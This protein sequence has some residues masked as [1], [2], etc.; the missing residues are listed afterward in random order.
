VQL[1]GEGHLA[2]DRHRIDAAGKVLTLVAVVRNDRSNTRKEYAKNQ[3]LKSEIN[4]SRTHRFGSDTTT[5]NVHPCAPY[6]DPP[7][8]W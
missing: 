1:V 4:A 3:H 2:V 7:I 6:L 8:T 5:R